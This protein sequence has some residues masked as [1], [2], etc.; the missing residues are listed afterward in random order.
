MTAL[1]LTSVTN[2]LLAGE[3]LFLAGM[4]MRG[5]KARFS[6]AW[7]WSGM[8]L[9]LGT[10]SLVGGI[11]HGFFEPAQMPRYAIQRFTWLLLAGMTFSLLMTAARQFFPE[12]QQ[13]ILLCI[14]VIQ[15]TA[16][17]IAILLV[18]D[19]RV[20]IVDY[21]PV[22]VLF[23]VMDLRRLAGDGS[24]EL[25]SGLLILAAA[26]AVQA[27]GFDALTPLDRNGLYHIIS[28][29]G[30]VFLY[31]GGRRLQAASARLGSLT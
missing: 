23:L 17:A 21:A 25:A 27:S 9:L 29:V 3:V 14:A 22:L 16:A 10:A 26:S 1:A 12:R 13:R 18:D 15:L 11:D 20:V 5:P 19:F 30:V 28:M 4:T 8:L 6:A 7:Y 31:L 24:W 2:F